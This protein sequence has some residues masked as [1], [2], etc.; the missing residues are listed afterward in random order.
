MRRERRVPERATTT[1]A[2]T[3]E[4]SSAV[5]RM[6][7]NLPSDRSRLAR[8]ARRPALAR[9]TRRRMATAIATPIA[10][11]ATTVPHVRPLDPEVETVDER[12]LENHVDHVPGDDDHERGPEVRDTPEVAL[13]SDREERRGDAECGDAKVRHGSTTRSAARHRSPRRSAARGRRRRSRTRQPKP[14]ESQRDCAPRRDAVTSSPAPT[15][16]AT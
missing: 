10:L 8:S 16:R 14:R 7:M 5:V 9:P 15:A 12:E 6:K 2:S 4:A 1:P 13:T 3:N 11:C